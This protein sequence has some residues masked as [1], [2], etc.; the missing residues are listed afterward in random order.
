MYLIKFQFSNLAVLKPGVVT[1][2]E[3]GGVSKKIFVSSGTVTV[4]EDASVQVLAEEAH[5]VENLDAAAIRDLVSSAQSELNS[6]SSEEVSFPKN[7]CYINLQFLFFLFRQKLKLQSVWKLLKLYKKL[8][9]KY[10]CVDVI[11]SSILIE[12]KV[13]K[14]KIDLIK[15]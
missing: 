15:I 9:N 3:S 13:E 7:V 8:Q 2:I 14:F 5:P 10:L 6:A 1:V 11:F 4:N 12:I